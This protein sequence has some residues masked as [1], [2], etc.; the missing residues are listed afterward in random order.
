[1]AMLET[2][3]KQKIF[4]STIFS[5]ILIACVVLGILLISKSVELNNSNG[6]IFGII[7]PIKL[8]KISRLELADGT[9]HGSFKFINSGLGIFAMFVITFGSMIG[10]WRSR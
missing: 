7:G 5:T 9:V 8:F 4:F 6:S 1:M 3:N 2:S 10:F